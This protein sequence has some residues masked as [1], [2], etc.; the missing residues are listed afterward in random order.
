[1]AGRKKLDMA[2]GADAASAATSVAAMPCAA[3]L[4]FWWIP[5]KSKGFTL[6]LASPLYDTESRELSGGGKN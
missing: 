4:C 5:D 2:D 6:L 3:V 1:M